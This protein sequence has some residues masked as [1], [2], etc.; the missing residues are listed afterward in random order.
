MRK[1][2]GIAVLFLIY[3]GL[4]FSFIVSREGV[5]QTYLLPSGFEGCVVIYYDAQDAL[6]L[7][8]ENNEIVYRVPKSGVIYTSSPYDFGWI[9]EEG[10]GSAQIR[11]FYVDQQ[12]EVIEELPQEKIRFG[13]LGGRGDGKYAKYY[14]YQIF[15]SKEMEDKG[16]H[17]LV[18]MGL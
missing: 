14:Y 4:I 18:E 5:D 10:S 9:S 13:A 16:C 6:P 1:I 7:K 17:E 3:I 8:I 2:I 12:G 11:A 15:G